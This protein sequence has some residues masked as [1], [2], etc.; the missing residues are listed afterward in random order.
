MNWSSVREPEKN[1]IEKSIHRK[2]SERSVEN[3][4]GRTYMSNKQDPD[5]NVDNGRKK[6]SLGHHRYSVVRSIPGSP[7]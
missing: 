1:A 3:K 4:V 2:P 7:K 6:K 5:G